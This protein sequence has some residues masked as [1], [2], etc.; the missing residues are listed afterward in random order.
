MLHDSIMT[1]R[2]AGTLADDRRTG[3]RV[4]YP[5]ELLIAWMHDLRTPVRY[6]VIDAG[7]GG[8][9]IRTRTPVIEG[10]TGVALKL[11][12]EGQA[13]DQSVMVAWTK[14]TDE[15]DGEYEIGLRYF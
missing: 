6:R 15:Q 10:M 8:F 11:L 13:I 12:P 14:A 4:P 7:D 1:S 2:L 9:R 3:D 5:A